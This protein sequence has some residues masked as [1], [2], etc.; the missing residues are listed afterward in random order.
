MTST[1]VFGEFL[2][3]AGEHITAAVS[4]RGDLPYEA[5]CGVVRQLHRLVATLARYLTDLP[6]PSESAA[7]APHR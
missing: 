3:S 2:G 5:Q 7:Q 4:F 6:L 1:P